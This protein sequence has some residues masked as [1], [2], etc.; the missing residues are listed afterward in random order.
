MR[1][2]LVEDDKALQQ[3]LHQQL[4]LQNYSVDLASDG[5]VTI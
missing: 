4:L 5:E 1:L 2:L 3:E